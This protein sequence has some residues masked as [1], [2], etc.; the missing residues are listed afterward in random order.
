MRETVTKSIDEKRVFND[1]I[2]AHVK[3]KIQVLDNSFVGKFAETSL[4]PRT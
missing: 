3:L 1:D 4:Q 2:Y